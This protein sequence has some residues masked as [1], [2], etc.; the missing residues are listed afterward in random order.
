MAKD[1]NPFGDVTKMIEQFKLPGVDM[2]AIVEARRKDIEALVKANKAAYEAMQ[3][4]A[5]KQ[6]EMLTQAM[7]DIQSAVKEAATTK[8]VLPDPKKQAEM[9]RNAWKKTLG[10]MKDLAEMARKSQ[11]DAMAGL[12][13]RASQSLQEIKKMMQPK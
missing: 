5:H 9:A 2:S 7:Q 12:T 10:D 4:M 8:G 11:A 6:T 1:S 3:A 13:A